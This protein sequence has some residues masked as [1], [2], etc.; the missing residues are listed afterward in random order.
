MT[1]IAPIDTRTPG[2]KLMLALLIAGL[3]AIPLF[4]TYL[5]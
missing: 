4:A 5:L 1:Q 2:W 3:L